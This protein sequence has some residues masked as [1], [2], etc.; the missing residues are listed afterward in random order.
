LLTYTAVF[1][2]VAAVLYVSFRA[3]SG[4]EP[5]AAEDYRTALVR[6]AG[7][8]SDRARLIEPLTGQVAADPPGE[9]ASAA[10][11]ALSGYQQR[12]SALETDVSGS[13]REALETARSLLSAAIEDYGWACRML[14]A[15]NHRDNLGVQRAIAAL[16][17]HGSECLRTATAVLREPEG[18]ESG[19]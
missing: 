9:V 3:L 4:G 8:V 2:V 13:E 14:E 1:V 18:V 6:I 12:L 19:R 5:V 15:G 11:K 10:R 16:C 17:E 7:F